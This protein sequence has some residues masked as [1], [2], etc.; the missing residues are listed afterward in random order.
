[1]FGYIRYDL[2][3]LFV[4]DLTL[5]KAMYCGL[6][7]GIAAACGQ[8][9]RIGLTYDVTFLSVLLHNIA[10]IDVKIEHQNCFEHMVKKRPIAVVDEL[11]R[12]LGALNTVLVYYKL[13]DDVADGDHG[14]ARRVWFRRGMK[15][16]KR[17][18]PEMVSLVE[19]YMIEQEKT[20]RERTASLDIAAEPSA[21]LMRDLSRFLLSDKATDHT[22]GLFYTL[23]KWIYLIDAL[24][25]IDKDQKKGSYNPFILS[26]PN[27]SKKQLVQKYGDDITFLFDT[28]FYGLREHLEQIEFHFNRDLSDNVLLRGL[29]LETRRVIKG[30]KPVKME[31]NLK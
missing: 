5:Y 19:R 6:C 20:E 7:K 14:K 31:V 13:T 9:A 26:Y 30:E 1:M 24:D 21:C 4:K 29:P 25:D 15:K 27:L 18:Y 8:T 11:T 12:Q 28:L 22:D 16:A 10:G 23:G 17:D 2:P 3:N